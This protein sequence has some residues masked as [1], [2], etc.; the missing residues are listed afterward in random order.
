MRT[1][2]QLLAN[3]TRIRSAQR[4]SLRLLLVRAPRG[5]YAPNRL[6]RMNHERPV[7]QTTPPGTFH[8]GGQ[9][10]KASSG[11]VPGPVGETWMRLNRAVKET[12]C[13]RI[14]MVSLR[15]FKHMAALWL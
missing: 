7:A 4:K 8:H 6:G 12:R 10:P 13:A 2:R 5:L 14:A 1:D 9:L 15:C 11:A 3:D